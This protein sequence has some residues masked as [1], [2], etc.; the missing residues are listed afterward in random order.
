MKHKRTISSLAIALACTLCAWA[1]NAQDGWTI[2]ASYNN[3]TEIAP[4]GNTCFALASGDLF[5]YDTTDGALTTYDKA[6]VMSDVEI[7]HIGWSR[8]AKRLVVVYT[9]SNIDFVSADGD[10]VNLSDLYLKTTTLDKTVNHIDFDGI[11]A[12]LSTAFGVVKLNVRD[13]VIMDTYQLD[14]NVSY[15]YVRDGYL[16]AETRE[17]GRLRCSLN[18]NLLDKKNWA[19]NG[20]FTPLNENLLD[21]KDEQTGYWW[22]KTEDGRLTYYTVDADNN[23]TYKTEG[24]QPEGPASNRFYRLY[25]HN[26]CLYGVGGRFSQEKDAKNP[27]EV[28][29]WDGTIWQLFEQPTQQQLGHRNEDY[30]CL[31]F[32]PKTEGHVMVGAKSGLYEFQDGKFVKCYNSDNSPLESSDAN[33]SQNYVMASGVKYDSDGALWVLNNKSSAAIKCLTRDGEWKS[34]RHSEISDDYSFDLKRPFISSRYDYLFF[35]NNYWESTKVFAYDYKSDKLYVVGGP[36]YTNEDLATINPY[37][38]YDIKEDKDHNI[39]IGTSA[40]PL[41]FSP[42]DMANGG[43][44]VTQ[45]KV[46]RNDGTNLADYL[47]A[48]TETRCVA[49]DGGNRKWIGTS[50]GVFLISDDCNTQVEH[51]TTENSPLPSDIVYDIL[52]SSTS[53]LVYFATDKG[54]CSYQSD[55]TTPSDEMK[56]GDVYAYPNPI[57]PDYTGDIT[58]VGLSYNADVKIVTTN[59]VLVNQ[60]RS[61]GGSYRWDGCDLNGKRVASGVYMVE[62]A[63]EDGK[64]G[65]VCKIAIIN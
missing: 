35:F 29:T 51:F 9:N 64:K 1:D 53:N 45:H 15:A 23:R 56:K 57:T 46:P 52:V 26:G 59:G 21:V 6:G 36:K 60:G 43:G 41:Y 7:K 13:A 11:Y 34:F 14:T 37:Y 16:Y 48:N 65:T 55:A 42:S 61:T 19:Y 12:Y 32:D 8:A 24:V 4:A 5:S 44:F 30:L 3:I 27:G 40:G 63:T 38:M 17:R 47:L 49:F 22:T 33:N 25:E 39:W 28:H 62:T 10:V 54:L 2:Y 31:D 50:N 58:I 20:A 18:D